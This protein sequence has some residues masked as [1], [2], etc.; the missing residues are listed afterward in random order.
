MSPRIDWR[1][2][3]FAPDV[4]GA[5]DQGSAPLA[6]ILIV[7]I[8]CFFAAAITW[9]SIAEIDELTRGEG[10]VIPSSQIQV[11]Q[12]LEG[13]IVQEI[14]VRTGELVAKDQ[15][16]LRIDDTGFS[17]SYGEVRANFY[18]VRAR[19][20]RLTAESEGTN[21]EFPPDLLAETRD[22]AL[23]EERLMSARRETLEQQVSILATQADQRRQELAEAKDRGS[24]LER[25][26]G[27]IRQEIGISAP[28]VEKGIVPR[29]DLLRLRRE[30]ADIDGQLSSTRLSIPRLEAA[31][32]E[33]SKRVEEKYLEFRTEARQELS[34]AQAELAAI[35]ENMRGARDRVARTEV[36]SPVNGLVKT[37]NARTIG[38]VLK[39][40]EDI[41]EIVP[42]DDTL[43]V[44][45]RI[46]PQDVAFLRP[47]QQATV[48][49]TAYD[50]SIY[51][52]LEGDLERISADTI[53]DP[54]T[55]EA[56]YEIVVR[57]ERNFLEH[58]GDQLPLMPGMV[59]SVDIL[60]GKR[61]ILDYLLKPI[62][63][64][65]QKA[66]TER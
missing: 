26:L 38:G 51:G 9:A 28:L 13:G 22:I 35:E 19:I 53:I 47:G 56:Y 54:Q 12:N 42:V 18:A 46:R 58:N 17:S 40:G 50:F 31:L 2:A 37:L 8:A 24:Q 62:L 25:S 7:L 41:V 43:L 21:L 11:V 1:D 23:N 57:T 4:A 3:D 16:L 20:A 61:T 14:L 44:Q 30:A 55:E 65:K 34:K 39:P 15:L 48:K 29:V 36:R 52:G 33:S 64:A 32:Q 60:T 45:A 10:K 5:R 66:L 59:A 6:G 49:F 27:L 63:K